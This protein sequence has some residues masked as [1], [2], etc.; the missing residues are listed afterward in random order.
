MEYYPILKGVHM[1]TAYLT[2]GLMLLRLGLDLAGKT[3]WRKTPLRWIPHLNDT[4]LLAAALVLVVVTAWMPLVHHWLTAKII[5]L[6][7]YIV[8][9]KWALDLKRSG[10]VRGVAAL[11][12]LFQ[13][14]LIFLL[15]VTKPGF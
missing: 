14:L 5:L 2:A 12:A 11:V 8:A 4:I 9:G 10:A 1:L 13:L 3:G 6:L 7:G 15:A